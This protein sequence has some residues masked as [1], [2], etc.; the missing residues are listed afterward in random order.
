MRMESLYEGLSSSWPAAVS[1]I[2]S[3]LLC[4][5]LVHISHTRFRR[6]TL[7]GK[8]HI[9]H[10]FLQK[11]ADIMPSLGEYQLHMKQLSFFN[12]CIAKQYENVAC[13]KTTNKDSWISD[14]CF[15]LFYYYILSTHFFCL[16]FF[17]FFFCCCWNTCFR[18]MV[19]RMLVLHR[20]TLC[21]TVYTVYV[22]SNNALPVSVS[23]LLRYRMNC[24]VTRDYAVAKIEEKNIQTSQAEEEMPFKETSPQG[25]NTD[26]MGKEMFNT[27]QW[28]L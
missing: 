4:W 7:M 11:H 20:L 8:Q 22:S 6:T 9:Q 5:C 21:F 26:K 18:M 12:F 10:L 14:F 27:S 24:G 17:S 28:C 3:G 13:R 2:C 1:F 19:F 25:Q 15:I 23:Y 16:L